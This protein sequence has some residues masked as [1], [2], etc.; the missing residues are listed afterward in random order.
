ML[1]AAP[2]LCSGLTRAAAVGR[3]PILRRVADPGKCIVLPTALTELAATLAELPTSL[4]ELTATAV[5]SL[6]ELATAVGRSWTS[7]TPVRAASIG[8]LDGIARLVAI[9]ALQLLPPNGGI[10]PA[11]LQGVLGAIASLVA[12][13]RFA[14]KLFT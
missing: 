13:I 7:V 4:P 11:I 5:T 1:T 2:G 14:S 8:A 9:G 3:L 10:R 12:R 6:P